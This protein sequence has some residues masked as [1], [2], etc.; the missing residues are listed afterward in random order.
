MA[1]RWRTVAVERPFRDDWWDE[2]DLEALPH[3]V[4]V[5]V[6]LGC[7]W[8]NV[9]LHLPS[10]FTAYAA[11]T[12]SPCVRVAVMDEYGLAWPWESPHVEALA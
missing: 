9:P 10:T 12:D 8:Q 11:L 6:Y 7:D 1:T 5:P 2:R 3:R 4:N